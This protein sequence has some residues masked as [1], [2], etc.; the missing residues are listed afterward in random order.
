MNRKEHTGAGVILGVLLFLLLSYFG[1]EESINYLFGILIG[2]FL[3]DIIEPPLHY[4]HRQYFHSVTF[5][6]YLGISLI[7]LFVLGI[8]FNWVFFLFF[9][10]IG[11]LL[12]LLLDSL[13]PM[14]LPA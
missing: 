3:P 5:A 14:G 13:T 4:T 9:I 11:Y 7:P 8:F 1:I 6:E 2:G 12:H 10:V